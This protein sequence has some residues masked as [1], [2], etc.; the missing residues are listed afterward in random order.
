LRDSNVLQ[1][2]IDHTL[3]ISEKEIKKADFEVDYARINF[4]SEW[5]VL[6]KLASTKEEII[7]MIKDA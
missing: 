4:L 6:S 2:G 7:G 3:E 1:I 5:Q